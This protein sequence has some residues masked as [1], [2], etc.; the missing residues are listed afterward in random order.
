MRIGKGA[1]GRAAGPGT[2]HAVLPDVTRLARLRSGRDRQ[3]GR[4]RADRWLREQ[5]HAGLLPRRPG[6]GLIRP[7]STSARGDVGQLLSRRSN[8][9]HR[10][11]YAIVPAWVTVDACR[12]PPI[13]RTR[14]NSPSRTDGPHRM[15]ATARHDTEYRRFR[16]RV[17]SRAIGA[18]SHECRS[19]QPPILKRQPPRGD[20]PYGL[21]AGNAAV[22]RRPAALRRPPRAAA[23]PRAPPS[24]GSGHGRVSGTCKSDIRG[25]PKSDSF[26]LSIPGLAA[27]CGG[28]VTTAG[29][30]HGCTDGRPGCC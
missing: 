10:S 6:H 14:R 17:S 4:K 13:A 25:N 28:E 29:T 8:D 15:P 1:S 7:R 16:R 3:Q 26:G 12:P 30:G 22:N 21:A 19:T 20:L 9:N 5:E 24:A 18:E 23:R 11:T 2:A 27:R